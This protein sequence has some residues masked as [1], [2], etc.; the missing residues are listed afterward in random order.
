MC[1]RMSSSCAS[2]C[3]ST[4]TSPVSARQSP[5]GTAESSTSCRSTPPQ[6]GR[7]PRRCR[8]R[9]K[10]SGC[11]R[12]TTGPLAPSRSTQART[13][14]STP[15]SFAWIL[16]Y[17][18]RD[19]IA[20]ASST[21]TCCSSPSNWRRCASSSHV[22]SSRLAITPSMASRSFSSWFRRSASASTAPGRAAA[23]APSPDAGPL[24]SG[25]LGSTSA[26][27]AGGRLSRT[28]TS[29]IG[30]SSARRLGRVAG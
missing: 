16:S 23:V 29:I 17:T 24:P 28:V 6:A 7:P 10:S 14:A 5:R 11:I 30:S 22:V 21:A 1:R 2:S 20:T 9:L 15:K 3:E 18:S 8:S 4:H 27:P 25:A 19:A 13:S 26:T 12:T